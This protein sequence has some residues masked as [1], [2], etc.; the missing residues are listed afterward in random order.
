M[1][2]TSIIILAAGSST[3]LGRP[4]QILP[5]KNSSLL[6][7]TI[8]SAVNAAVGPVIVVTG[9]NAK[10]I[11][12]HIG[13][14]AVAV[15]FNGEHPEGIA[16]SIRAGVNYV[17]EHHSVGKRIILMVC[18]QPYVNESLLKSLIDASSN[19]D[20]PLAACSYK[21]TIGVPALFDRRFFPE[22]LSL[23]GEEG[24]KKI[25]LNHERLVAVVTFP[26]GEIDIDSAADVDALT[27][28]E[29]NTG[30]AVS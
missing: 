4:K 27:H 25:L 5:Y 13:N 23:K 19:A 28:R 22:L 11:S 6:K 12:D 17:Q 21:G 9:A 16:S 30:D 7:H 2:N 8:K 18:D 26:L 29:A 14:D 20:K 15:V 3:R 10:E 1:N 24:G